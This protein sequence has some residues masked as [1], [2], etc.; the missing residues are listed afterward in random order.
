MLVPPK[1][2]H[3]VVPPKA[4]IHSCAPKGGSTLMRPDNGKPC[5]LSLVWNKQIALLACC[6]A[7]FEAAKHRSK[8]YLLALTGANVRRIADPRACLRAGSP[9]YPVSC[10]SRCGSAVAIPGFSLVHAR[11]SRHRQRICLLRQMSGKYEL[12]PISCSDRCGAALP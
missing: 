10:A 9:G 1:E 8:L 6:L 3:I 5:C 12:F 2:Q 7:L 11:V 4:A